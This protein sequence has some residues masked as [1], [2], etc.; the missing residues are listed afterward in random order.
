VAIVQKAKSAVERALNSVGRV[1]LS[2]EEHTRL[3]GFQPTAAQI[4][5]E[6]ILAHPIGT[7]PPDLV[8]RP[9]VDNSA[10]ERIAARI[11]R[12]YEKAAREEPSNPMRPKAA[13]LWTEV[14]RAEFAEIHRNIEARDPAALARTLMNFGSE[15]G[16][17]GGFSFALDGY[18][19]R[20]PDRRSVAASYHDKLVC[21]AES[22]GVL[23]LENPEQGRW[24]QNMHVDLGELVGE[25][26]TELGITLEPPL[27]VVPVTGIDTGRGVYHYR[28]ANAIYAAWRMKSLVP[29][30]SPVCEFGGGNGITAYYAFRMGF[31]DYTIFDLPIVSMFA[32]HFLLHALGEEAVTLYG[33]DAS[34]SRISLLPYWKCRDYGPRSFAFAL[35]QDSFPEIDADLVREYLS[36]IAATTSTYFL[37]INQESQATMADTLQLNVPALVKLNGR[38]ERLCRA[39][40]WIREGWVEELY[41]IA[42]GSENSA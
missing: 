19:H 37:S 2:T 1:I 28:H 30:G 15:P 3:K 40:Y 27:G 39:R 42:R 13:D 21:L 26:E 38:F 7:T 16:T 8:I 4:R 25:L 36:V 5:A 12:A 10:R 31:R 41:E 17:F 11:L 20:D 34:A 6:A 9:A 29:A 32:A 35:N 23:P 14:V 22:I 18:N 24:D 33:E